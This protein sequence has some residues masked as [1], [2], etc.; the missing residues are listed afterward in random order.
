MIK[1][2]VSSSIIHD[3]IDATDFLSSGISPQLQFDP[4]TLL[5][6]NHSFRIAIV[7][8]TNNDVFFMDNSCGL[9]GRY[10]NISEAL[11]AGTPHEG[12]SSEPHHCTDQ[13]S[14]NKA[15]NAQ[16]RSRYPPVKMNCNVKNGTYFCLAEKRSRFGHFQ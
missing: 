10:K 13:L 14:K 15:K 11:P 6:P 5:I 8:R 4:K 9:R 7:I 2:V 16:D 12:P 3:P 1:L